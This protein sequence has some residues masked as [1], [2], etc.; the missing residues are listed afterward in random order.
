M[1]LTYLLLTTFIAIAFYVQA[2]PTT[3]IAT[4]QLFSRP[5][6]EFI[7]IPVIDEQAMAQKIKS[8]R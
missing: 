7:A 8:I 6:A 1:F 3:A 4:K 2:K 5:Q